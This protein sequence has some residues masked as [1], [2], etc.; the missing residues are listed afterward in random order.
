MKKDNRNGLWSLGGLIVQL[1]R[2]RLPVRLR[3]FV[4]VFGP[5]GD[6]SVCGLHET[7]G[8]VRDMLLTPLPRSLAEI[9][10]CDDEDHG[11]ENEEDKEHRSGQ[12]FI[13]W[14]VLVPEVSSVDEW[15]GDEPMDE[16]E[17]AGREIDRLVFGPD[18]VGFEAIDASFRFGSIHLGWGAENSWAGAKA[19]SFGRGWWILSEIS[20][21]SLSGNLSAW[22]RLVIGNFGGS[23]H[24]PATALQSYDARKLNTTSCARFRSR[25]RSGSWSRSLR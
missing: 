5:H 16:V 14:L 20:S 8:W 24:W 21:E 4:H 3:P 7:T 12:L 22:R 23:H 2:Q 19:S 9:W 17:G 11:E 25:L 18:C 6:L 15:E 13:L 10:E 1:L